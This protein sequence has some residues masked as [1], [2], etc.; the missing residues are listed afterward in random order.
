MYTC[1]RVLVKMH[2][3]ARASPCVGRASRCEVDGDTCGCTGCLLLTAPT[4]PTSPAPLPLAI[5]ELPTSG[6]SSAD[7]GELLS[8][9]FVYMSLYHNAPNHLRV[10]QAT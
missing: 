1:V 2:A 5:Q 4:K 9:A 3:R 6:W 7:V 10:T 8:Q